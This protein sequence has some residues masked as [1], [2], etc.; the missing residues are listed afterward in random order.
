[1]G[2]ILTP[3]TTWENS[4]SYLFTIVSQASSVVPST[5]QDLREYSACW[6]L[7]GSAKQDCLVPVSCLEI[8]L[9]PG[10]IPPSGHTTLTQPQGILILILQ[11]TTWS[12]PLK[13]N[14]VW[15][16]EGISLPPKRFPTIFPSETLNMSLN[17]GM[18]GTL[19]PVL[20]FMVFKRDTLTLF[21]PAPTPIWPHLSLQRQKTLAPEITQPDKVTCAP[22]ALTLSSSMMPLASSSY[23][24]KT[25]LSISGKQI[26][27]CV[28][29]NEHCLH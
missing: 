8:G 26:W 11:V 7:A 6:M 18:P 22:S 23:K 20:S 25:P 16:L 10:H 12:S 29:R 5:E 9:L 24:I 13:D 27:L 17:Q 14:P 19:K 4:L 28:C 15:V 3:A 2:T 1:M 21:P